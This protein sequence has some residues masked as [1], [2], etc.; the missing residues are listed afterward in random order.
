LDENVKTEDDIYAKPE[1][2]VIVKL[3][4]L[5]NDLPSAK[6]DSIPPK[7]MTYIKGLPHAVRSFHK[8][9]SKAFK[10]VRM[11]LGLAEEHVKTSKSSNFLYAVAALLED[12]KKLFLKNDIQELPA[13][14]RDSLNLLQTLTSKSKYRS[15]ENL[16]KK[17]IEKSFN[18]ADQGKNLYD[19]IDDMFK[20]IVIPSPLS[21]SAP[22]TSST[23]QSTSQPNSKSSKKGNN[24]SNS[25]SDAT[26]NNKKTTIHRL[27][28][29]TMPF[30]EIWNKVKRDNR[31]L[32]N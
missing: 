29:L 21:N 28:R 24:N 19:D 5:L 7:D 18:N 25:T 3:S 23:T 8:T 26:P 6:E 14:K 2:N 9:T 4:D 30:A 17:A 11:R 27:E 32:E 16:R 22:V 15:S 10:E 12:A 31:Y 1:C 20:F 13:R